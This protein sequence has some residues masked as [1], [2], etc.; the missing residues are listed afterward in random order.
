LKRIKGETNL[1]SLEQFSYLAQMIASAG[2]VL[3][4]VFVGFQ[5]KQSTAALQRNEH[6][7]TMSQWTVIRMAI[8]Q[9]REVSELMAG[10]L[11]GAAELDGADQ[12]RLDYLLNEFAWASFHIWDRTKRGVFPPGTFEFSCGSLLGDLLRTPR[13][14]IW[15]QKAATVGLI[16]DF[17]AD[18]DAMLA[19]G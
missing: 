2:V 13:G 11:Y 19:R 6:N 3:S 1:M 15:W 14:R 10:G 17:V 4:L 18:V 8:V 9:N 5:I 16:P 7:S 12:L